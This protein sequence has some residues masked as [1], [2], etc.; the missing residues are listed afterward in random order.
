MRGPLV[1][2]DV[3]AKST[4]FILTV[5]LTV[6]TSGAHL[7]ASI[8]LFLLLL[9]S[10][11]PLLP[12]AHP[13]LDRQHLGAHRL[14]GR[15]QG[16]AAPLR[17]GRLRRA[18]PV[19][20]PRRRG[21]RHAGAGLPPPRRRRAVVLWGERGGRLQRGPV[22]DPARGSRQLPR[23]RLPQGPDADLPRRAAG[24]RGGGRWRRHVQERL[25][26]VPHR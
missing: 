15:R 20:G 2:S 8:F 26:G 18:A 12:G 3:A 7:S 9:L 1:R 13:R 16:R 17:H 10:L 21:A 22:G 25:P 19:Q 5:T 11:P 14:S 4:P 24:A 6:I 23:P